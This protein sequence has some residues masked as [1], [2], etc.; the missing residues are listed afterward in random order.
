MRDRVFVSKG[1]IMVR[2]GM[3]AAAL[4]LMASPLLAQESTDDLKKELEQLRREVDG[5]KAVN[6][7]KE[8]PAMGKI[9][10]DAMAA[11]DNP[12]MTLFKG[13]KLSGHV[14]VAYGFSFN[15]LHANPN[16][17]GSNTGNNPIRVFDNQ[18]H[19]FTLHTVQLNLERLATKDMIVGYHIELMYGSDVKW[20][21]AT[22]L[23]IQ[24]GW[25]Q[26]LAPVGNGLDIRVGKM[27]SLIGYEV[28]ENT[29]NLNYTRGVVWGQAEPITATGV[30]ATYSIVEQLSATI[31]FNNG[32]N[33]AAFPA[34]LPTDFDTDHGKAFEAQVMA[35]P[36]KDLWIAMNF[37]VGN[38]TSGGLLSGASTAD[39]FYI[40]NIVSEYKMD[41]LTL[42]LNFTQASSQ[43]FGTE[44]VSIRAPQRG[45]A[46]YGK[47]Q[48]TDAFATGARIEYFSDIKG[49]I[50]TTGP[51]NDTGNG[52]RIITFT[53]TQELKVAQHLIL[54]FEFRHDNSNQHT[55]V[56]GE[57]SVP[58]RGD[59]SIAFEALLPF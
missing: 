54:R 45:L 13:T 19:S 50:L 53:L 23:G 55:F 59:N 20:F 56:R 15:Q 25:I 47:Y 10:A 46:V 4:A 35:K 44:S 24:E 40:F 12:V 30:R 58:A 6:S 9:D 5:L 8:L 26:I 57:S 7:T 17:L 49:G 39:K 31:G 21:D 42:A 34:S 2:F 3:V 28:V 1:E 51:G 52:A 37:L 14:D 43:G 16:G 36:I 29:N 33:F 38:D 22:S 27:A 18:D 41:K 48:L 11:D 32:R